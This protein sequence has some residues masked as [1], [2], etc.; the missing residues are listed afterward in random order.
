MTE[1]AVQSL[2]QPEPELHGQRT[3]ET[4][5]GTQ[6]VGEFLL[7]VGRQH[8]DQRISRRDVHEHEAHQ[9]DADDDRD[10]IDDA[11]GYVDEHGLPLQ[12]V[13]LARSSRSLVIAG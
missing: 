13:I 1:I 5:G 8:R 2:P 10:H 6:L 11:A 3:I 4:V 9:R 12:V 7:R